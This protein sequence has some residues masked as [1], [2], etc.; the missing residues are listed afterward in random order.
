MNISRTIIYVLAITLSSCGQQND[1]LKFE[2][3]VMN[4]IYLELVDSLYYEPEFI[5]PPPAPLP[6]IYFSTMSQKIK[7]NIYESDSIKYSKLITEFEK[8]IEKIKNYSGK[9]VIIVSDTV[10]Q[11]HD[12]YQRKINNHFKLGG[13]QTRISNEAIDYYSIDLLHFK[14]S[15]KY[16][17]KY[18]SEFPL[19]SEIWKRKYDFHVYCKVTFSRIQFD[20]T[21]KYGV[22]IGGIIFGR[23]SGHGVII[24]IRKESNKWV[25]DEIVETWAS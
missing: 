24:Y 5:P 22:L 14:N 13:Q 21:K 17:F 11:L 7:D 19:G 10:H 4:E 18:A 1:D 6:D 12:S 16:I 25:I 3:E 2:K 23:R 8:R 9:K 20:K 15:K